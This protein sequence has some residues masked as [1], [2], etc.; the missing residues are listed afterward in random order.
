[1]TPN[2]SGRLARGLQRLMQDAGEDLRIF[3]CPCGYVAFR[4]G[5][6]VDL[7]DEGAGWQITPHTGCHGCGNVPPCP[8]CGRSAVPV[9][10]RFKSATAKG[11]LR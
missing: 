4:I 5:H 3:V 8:A 9:W 10:D 7:A 2:E 1:M 11:P 6:H